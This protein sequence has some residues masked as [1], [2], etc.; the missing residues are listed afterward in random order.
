[1]NQKQR[2]SIFLPDMPLILEKLLY[3]NVKK[4]PCNVIIL[5]II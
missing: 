3:G 5:I 1:M 4:S 2:G